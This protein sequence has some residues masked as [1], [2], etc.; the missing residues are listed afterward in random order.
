MKTAT[1][2]AP[3]RKAPGMAPST[4][5][6]PDAAP[7]GYEVGD[8]VVDIGQQRV[9][10]G[11]VEIPLPHLSFDLLVTLAR[12][13]PNLVTFD[14]LIARVWPGL[15]ITPETISQRVKLVRSALGDDPH[16]PR[17]I[18]GVRGRGYRMVAA[19][20]PLGARREESEPVAR[21][22]PYWMDEKKPEA[23]PP[24]DSTAGA[25]R[26]DA[27][28]APESAVPATPGAFGWVGALLIVL[29][30]LAVP[31]AVSHF[32]YRAP[33]GSNAQEVIVQPPTRTIA[34]LPL[35]DTRPSGDNAYLSEGLAQ[36]LSARLSRIHGL[37][38]A[39][40]TSASA[41]KDRDVRTI[42]QALGVRH[43]LEGSVHREGDQ[44]RVTAQL[45]DASTGYNVWSQTYNRTWQD[46]LAIEDDVARSI[47]GTLKVVLSNQP[48]KDAQ[49][50]TTHI[51]AFDLYLSGLAKLHGSGG[52]DELDE[53]GE[54]F[55]RALAA[56]PK[57]ALAYAGL[58][59][60]YVFGYERTLD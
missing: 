38:V 9:A 20:R 48:A 46:L 57:F 41:I 54:S 47:T 4:T 6:A 11:G 29:A 40:R 52:T 59:E 53:A 18:G 16:A 23:A 15:V 50:A 28:S 58:C 36:E 24:A 32:L 60:R 19:V 37:R 1:L 17:Y 44:L 55:R 22:T 30:L 3:T 10:R 51:E 8:V 25:G 26:P 33:A 31:W 13:A 56:D 27:A 45:V 43:V 34:V 12:A 5:E 2:L 49:P 14:Q 39:S 7:T 35:V 42:A 21:V